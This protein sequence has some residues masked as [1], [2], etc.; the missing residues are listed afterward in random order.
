MTFGEDMSYNHGPTFSKKLFDEFLLP[1]YRR[2]PS[3]GSKS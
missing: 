2:V 1:Y 3:P